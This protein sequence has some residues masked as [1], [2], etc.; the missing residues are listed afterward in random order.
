MLNRG[1]FYVLYL[2]LLHLPPLRFHSVGG[3]WDQYLKMPRF[4]MLLHDMAY[5]L[6]HLLPADQADLYLYT[7]RRK[8]KREGEQG[9][10][11]SLYIREEEVG[12][13]ET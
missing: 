5:P 3:C 7:E 2:T 10:P 12:A 9:E 13:K 1:I 11:V 8:T 4:Y 6:P